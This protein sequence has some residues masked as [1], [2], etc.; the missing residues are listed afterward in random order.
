MV[1]TDYTS[2]LESYI[3][4]AAYGSFTT[5]YHWPYNYLAI[6]H[7]II[8]TTTDCHPRLLK[9]LN[10]AQYAIHCVLSCTLFLQSRIHLILETLAGFNE[11]EELLDL[12]IAKLRYERSSLAPLCIT[13][14][15]ILRREEA[16]IYELNSTREKRQLGLAGVGT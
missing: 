11:E 7:L 13:Q 3:S 2:K 10:T 4:D 5:T 9:R 1:S 12:N 16:F 6:N 15:I 14:V 8:A